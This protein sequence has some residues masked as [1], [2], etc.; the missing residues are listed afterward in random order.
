ME[1]MGL[2]GWDLAQLD[3]THYV[4]V[5]EL[6]QPHTIAGNASL[7]GMNIM[8]HEQSVAISTALIHASVASSL[9]CL[10]FMFFN[11]HHRQFQ[12]HDTTAKQNPNERDKSA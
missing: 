3:C 12:G 7:R 5:V 4:C 9:Q 2:G 6:M 10:K 1:M 11:L 8:S